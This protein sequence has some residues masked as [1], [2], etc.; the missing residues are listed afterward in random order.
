MKANADAVASLLGSNDPT[1]SCFVRDEANIGDQAQ[2]RI[3]KGAQI[4]VASS[5]RGQVVWWTF[6][7]GIVG[8]RIIEANRENEVV[9]ALI[10]G[11][12]MCMTRHSNLHINSDR[13]LREP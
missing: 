1:A 5:E 2:F 13:S 9:T 6:K 4:A 7:S 11:Y 12:G 3:E 8:V 10:P